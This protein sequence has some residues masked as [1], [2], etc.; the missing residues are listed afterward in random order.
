MLKLCSQLSFIQK[1]VLLLRNDLI[2]SRQKRYFFHRKLLCVY[3]NSIDFRE[4]RFARAL[5]FAVQEINNSSD[6]LP[7]ITLGYHI[8]DSCASVPMAIK[9]AM[10]LANGLDLVFNDT[11]SCGKSAAVPAL[12]G[13]SASTPA[14]TI[15]RLLGPLGIPQV[16]AIKRLSLSSYQKEKCWSCTT[17]NV[18]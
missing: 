16:L 7:G 14:V 9:V 2:R 13:D 3:F 4:L 18:E 8:Y 6:L 12:V 11:D 1:N 10:Q 5:Q 17:I 15:S